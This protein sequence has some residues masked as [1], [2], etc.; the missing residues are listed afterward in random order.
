MTSINN[1]KAEQYQ[2]WWSNNNRTGVKICREMTIDLWPW[3]YIVKDSTYVLLAE[4]NLSFM[5]EL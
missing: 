2:R 4:V 1:Y 3:I 5:F